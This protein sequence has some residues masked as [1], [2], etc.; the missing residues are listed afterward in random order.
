MAKQLVKKR[1]HRRVVDVRGDKNM[2]NSQDRRNT[3]LLQS[4]IYK[5][6]PYKRHLKRLHASKQQSGGEYWT[7]VSV[8]FI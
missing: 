4:S 6:K 8:N 1:R 2:Q 5:Q 3:N 7:F